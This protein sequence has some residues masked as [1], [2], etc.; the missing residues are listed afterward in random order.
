M[1]KIRIPPDKSIE[2]R[3][4]RKSIPYDTNNS[5]TAKFNLEETKHT[6][7][8]LVT[9]TNMV[10][11][12]TKNVPGF[13][14][15]KHRDEATK[16]GEYIGT[17]EMKR[18]REPERNQND[19][20]VFSGI[21]DCLDNEGP[22]SIR[23]LIERPDKP[24]RFSPRI[25]KN[26]RSDGDHPTPKGMH[27]QHDNGTRKLAHPLSDFP[28]SI[29]YLLTKETE[30]HEPP[31]RFEVSNEAAMENWKILKRHNFNIESVSAR[32]KRSAM[33]TG[34]EFKST[35][36]LERLLGAHPRWKKFKS[37]LDRGVNFEL[38]KLEE[39]LRQKDLDAAYHRGNHKSAKRNEKFLSDAMIKEIMQG[40]SLILPGDRYRE[41]PELVLNPMGVATHLGVTS[42]GEFLPKNRVTH[43]LSFPG[44]FS[45]QSVNSRLKRTS[46]EP[47]M[48]SYVLLR[49][50]HYIVS[51]REKF[52]DR[53]IWIRKEDFKSA[54]RRL[55]L[56]NI[57]ALR[58]A[59]RVKLNELYYI[60]ISLRQPFGGAPCPSEFAVIADV[61]TDTINDL[62]ECKQWDHNTLYSDL[63]DKVPAEKQL[64]DDIPY[65]QARKMSVRNTATDYGKADVYVDD[66][67]TIAVDKGENL[68][69]IT[70]APITV[71]HAV[72][73]RT[74]YKNTSI[75][76]KDIVADDK[77]AA[78][79]AAEEQ[80]ICLGWLLNTRELLVKLPTHKAIA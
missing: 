57:T 74:S 75:K 22:E 43:D 67:I 31:C 23:R 40:W 24:K 5:S 48:F 29:E 8:S 78:E 55:H 20:E 34:S 9:T 50:I 21:D 73:D 35:H 72:A 58:S 45:G 49:T 52:P 15:D 46:L 2:V 71:M 42:T 1:P 65:Q 68:G 76:R 33:T 6:K 28:E 30:I 32:S 66:I 77:M 79:G 70:R 69:R 51:L 11:H 80:K 37:I 63:A 41:I 39:D 61:I 47:C 25:Y 12:M 54:F 13:A 60:L 16:L 53:R 56:N 59:V 10:E 3:S 38:E 44:K 17:N 19:D 7:D 36:D 26:S 4:E 27:H 64:D 14:Q 62:L 18:D